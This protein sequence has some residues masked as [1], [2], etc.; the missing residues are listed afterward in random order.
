MAPSDVTAKFEAMVLRMN[1]PASGYNETV[2]F[3][4]GIVVHNNPKKMP[5]NC[6]KIEVDVDESLS[7]SASIEVAGPKHLKFFLKSKQSINSKL[8]QQLYIICSRLGFAPFGSK[9][10]SSS[11]ITFDRINS[12]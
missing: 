5:E 4:R 12:I 9:F 7:S 6:L 10:Y 1:T 11:Q 3:D 2:V 8:Q